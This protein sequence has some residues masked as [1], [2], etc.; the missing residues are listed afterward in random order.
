MR[1][2][3]EVFYPSA[4]NRLRLFARDYPTADTN[5]PTI[6]LL[7][8]HGLSR[9]SADFEPLIEGLSSKHRIIVPDQRGR[10]KS[11]YETDPSRYRP[12]VY[13]D[14]MWALLDRLGIER[15]VCIGT[16]M[17]GLMAMMMAGD[18]PRRV[19]ERVR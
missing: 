1:S 12:D 9:N 5:K 15:A 10:G 17:G 2:Y 13:V 7:M 6:P 14:D 19:A 8:M 11:G 18:R 4:D 3:D 16:S